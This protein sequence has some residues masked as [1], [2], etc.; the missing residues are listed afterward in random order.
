M[1]PKITRLVI[2]HSPRRLGRFFF[3]ENSTLHGARWILFAVLLVNLDRDEYFGI[4]SGLGESTRQILCHDHR[5]P[6]AKVLCFLLRF[7]LDIPTEDSVAL[8]V[9]RR[10]G[11]LAGWQPAGHIRQTVRVC[12]RVNDVS[13][14]W[15]V[16]TSEDFFQTWD[17]VHFRNHRSYPLLGVY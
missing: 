6:V 16:V 1:R 4:G 17:E 12:L 8:E 5:C 10:E 2:T 11:N 13:P 3:G 15:V 9:S 14:F 7:V